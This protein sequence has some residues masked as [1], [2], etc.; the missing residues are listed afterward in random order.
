MDV[1]DNFKISKKREGNMLFTT[2]LLIVGLLVLR[3]FKVVE[4]TIV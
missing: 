4:G 3:K 1:V 2:A